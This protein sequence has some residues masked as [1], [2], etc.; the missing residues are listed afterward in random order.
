MDSRNSL[1]SL[2]K[3][4]DIL[5]YPGIEARIFGFSG[6]RILKVEVSRYYRAVTG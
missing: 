3:K 2:E 6:P 5:L 4:I 1:D